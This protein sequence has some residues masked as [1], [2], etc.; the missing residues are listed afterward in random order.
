M[1]T[2]VLGSTGVY[3][4][5]EDMELD[6]NYHI[7][8]TEYFSY[9]RCKSILSTKKNDEITAIHVNIRSLPSRISDLTILFLF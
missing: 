5:E 8:D 2:R 7:E 6:P 1:E 4:Y 9:E 3:S